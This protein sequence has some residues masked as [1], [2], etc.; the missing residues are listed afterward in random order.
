MPCLIYTPHIFLLI[1]Y[2]QIES[3]FLSH[4]FLSF[5]CFSK[6]TYIGMF[7][8]WCQNQRPNAQNFIARIKNKKKL[9]N[10]DFSL[11]QR[12]SG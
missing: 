12:F 1:G 2:M 3:N 8:I 6:S 5:C 7:E 11:M 4:C 10:Y 9:G